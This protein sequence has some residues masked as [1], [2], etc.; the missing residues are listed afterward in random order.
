VTAM[1]DATGRAQQ[2]E[3]MND[4]PSDCSALAELLCRVCQ[5]CLERIAEASQI[6]ME[7]LRLFI[8]EDLSLSLDDAASIARAFLVVRSNPRHW[9]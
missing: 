8:W 7:T 1:Q 9:V 2:G 5:D 3:A 4:H 6:D